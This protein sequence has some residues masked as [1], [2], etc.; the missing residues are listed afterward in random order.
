MKEKKLNSITIR[1]DVETFEAVEEMKWQQRQ[2]QSEL[3]RELI[4]LGLEVKN[5]GN[6]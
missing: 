3:L 4:K 5:G 2:K 6:K 1:L